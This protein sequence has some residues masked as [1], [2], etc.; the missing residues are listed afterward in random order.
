MSDLSSVLAPETAKRKT[1][2][3]RNRP[4]LSEGSD[5][6]AW[7]MVIL[8]L[9]LTLLFM[10][11]AHGEEVEFNFDI[12]PST[13]DKAL[14]L[15][16]KQANIQLLFSYEDVSTVQLKALSGRYSV[17]NGLETLIADACIQVAINAN[18]I[19]GVEPLKLKRRFWFMKKKNCTSR[20]LRPLAYASTLVAGVAVNGAFAQDASQPGPSPSPLLSD[21]LEEIVVTARRRDERLQDVPM[22]IKAIT[23]SDLQSFNLF[24]GSD[25][26]AITP[27][28]TFKPRPGMGDPTVALRG[29]AKPD[30]S[31]ALPTVQT[32]LNEVPVTPTLMY[33]AAYDI[34]QIEVLRGPQGTLRGEPASSGAITVTTKRPDPSATEGRVSLNASTRSRRRAEAAL[35]LPI[36]ENKFALRFAGITDHGDGAGVK[37]ITTSKKSHDHTDSWRVASYAQPLDNIKINL[38]YQHFSADRDEFPWIAGPGYSGPGMPANFNGPAIATRDRRSVSHT[39]HIRTQWFKH[40]I[41]DFSW[42]INDDYRLI[43]VGSYGKTKADDYGASYTD[44]ESSNLWIAPE[45]MRRITTTAEVVTQ[46]LRLQA[47]YRDSLDYGLGAYYRREKAFTATMLPAAFLPGAFGVRP[48]LGLD[49][50][51]P[52][53]R[54]S[55]KADIPIER[56]EKA[57]Y[58]NA[59]VHLTDK[60]DAFLGIRYMEYDVLIRQSGSVINGV[61]ATGVP[62][63]MC[64]YV[65]SA[66]GGPAFPSTHR[67]GQ[68]DL[69]LPDFPISMGP[70][71]DKT[72][73]PLVY[74]AS[75]THHINDDVTT[76]VSYGHSWRPGANNPAIQSNDPRVTKYANLDPEESNNV[77]FGVKTV[78]LDGQLALNLSLFHQKFDNFIYQVPFISY[79]N[80][81][82]LPLSVAS[83]ANGMQANADGKIYGLDFDF[84][85]KS[86]RNFS[87]GGSL[88]YARSRLAGAVLPCNDAN[89]DG[90]ADN[91]A[92]TL[93]GFAAAGVPIAL[94]TTKG[95]FSRNADWY[96]SVQAE[97]DWN[98]SD[99]LDAY[100]RALMTYTP[101]NQFASPGFEA[102]AYTITNLY[103]GLRDPGT[104]WDIGIYINNVF[105]QKTILTKQADIAV[106]SLVQSQLG[107]GPSTGYSLTSATERREA[108]LTVRYGF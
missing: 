45:K 35:N 26:A 39:P 12:P 72:Y 88:S 74:Q 103:A 99:D 75:L 42:D 27:G 92:P 96:A 29:A 102:D 33:Q 95:S 21:R 69:P 18:A 9:A 61:V 10:A 44:G 11:V 87:V 37:S 97:K 59:T 58:G 108:G 17:T 15:F 86:S 34:Q 38:M 28:L 107:L 25:L 48:N 93:D 41:G 85:Y 36:I 32:Y 100:F 19:S 80:D 40:W 43:Y 30:S 7:V 55:T 14:V 91:G 20:K 101:K 68:C 31:T 24:N 4:A 73:H 77:E 81:T 23:D 94:C 5:G 57:I 16:A 65:P 2:R 54:Y 60:T 70:D 79:V 53:Y 84:A 105:D 78:L 50:F 64:S 3:L 1:W 47:S 82:A 63:S 22:A 89:F 76:Y 13:A 56:E 49:Q 52:Y 67:P 66:G 106:P 6:V 90:V 46:E 98:V 62:D 8:V 51:D 83:N 71:F 104:Q